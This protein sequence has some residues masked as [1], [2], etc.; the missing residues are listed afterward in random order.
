[1]N[2][3]SVIE[4]L[5][6]YRQKKARIAVLST[7]T[8]GGG[9][10]VSRLNEDDQLQALHRQLRGMPSYMYL[11]KREQ[12][13]ETTA[14]V[15]LGRYPAGTR[16]QLAA[17]PVQGADQEDTKKLRELRDKIRK[18]IEARAG[19]VDD[20]DAVLDRIAEL[21][22][23]R[24]EVARVESILE[25]LASYEPD[26]AKILRMRYL[27]GKD[28]A[29]IRTDLRVSNRTYWRRITD[30]EREFIKLAQ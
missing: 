23:L 26:Y 19:Q 22:D 4:Q 11:S 2:E 27:E 1:M 16:A 18:V 21:Q 15:Y 14:H 12:E 29:D 7:Y 13:L 24:A 28:I 8:V 5:T 20:F 17:V 30:A 9:I 3:Q 6:S 10:T 25:A